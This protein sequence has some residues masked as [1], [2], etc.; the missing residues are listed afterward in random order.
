MSQASAIEQD[1]NA[2]TSVTPRPGAELVMAIN[3]AL[4]QGRPGIKIGVM[5]GSDEGLGVPAGRAFRI[6]GEGYAEMWPQLPPLYE[7]VSDRLAIALETEHPLAIDGLSKHDRSQCNDLYMAALYDLLGL[8]ANDLTGP[9]PSA[10]RGYADESAARRSVRRGRR[11]W[12][13]LGGWPWFHFPTGPTPPV[14][15]WSQGPAP[16]IAKAFAVWQTGK[17]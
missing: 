2:V 17:L 5:P 3:T 6:V 15:W 14:D 10:G 4:A 9:Q 11:L 7:V 1:R 16:Q 8:T 12:R 13:S